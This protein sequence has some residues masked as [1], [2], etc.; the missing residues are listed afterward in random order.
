M[1]PRFVLLRRMDLDHGRMQKIAF[2]SRQ[3]E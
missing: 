1:G 3:S 2:R